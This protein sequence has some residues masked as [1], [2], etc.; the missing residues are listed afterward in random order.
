MCPRQLASQPAATN[1]TAV[2]A[3]AVD[4]T[5]DA[6]LAVDVTRRG[7]RHPFATGEPC[8]VLWS[9]ETPEPGSHEHPCG[10][11]CALSFAVWPGEG[12][13]QPGG[14][15]HLD[16]GRLPFGAHYS[17]L[18]RHSAGMVASRMS[19]MVRTPMR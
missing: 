13:D 1:L 9:G 7:P 14:L 6:R 19:S 17:R 16:S 18:R 10:T 2:V 12:R 8:R 11:C 15:D 3:A 4:L 5:R